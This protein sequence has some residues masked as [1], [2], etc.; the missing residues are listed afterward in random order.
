M[1]DAT[2]IRDRYTDLEAQYRERLRALQRVTAMLA[3]NTATVAAVE[4]ELGGVKETGAAMG[5]LL[6]CLGEEASDVTDVTADDRPATGY[7][8]ARNGAGVRDGDRDAAPSVIPLSRV[9]GP[10]RRYLPGAYHGDLG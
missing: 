6:Y 7:S 3:T 8:A 4:R 1:R 5:A 2:E 10:A 9:G